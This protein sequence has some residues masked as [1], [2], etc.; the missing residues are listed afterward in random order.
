[1]TETPQPSIAEDDFDLDDW[2]STGTLARRA[3][4]IYNDPALAAEYDILAEQV[5]AAERAAVAGL[6]A[7]GAAAEAAMGDDTDLPELYEEMA[8][9][10]ER[11]E[12]SKAVWIVR[13]LVEDEVDAI[14]KLHPDPEIPELIRVEKKP[15]EVWSEEQLAAGRQYRE[16][17][18]AALTARNLAMIAKAVVEVRTPRGV[19]RT[20]DTRPAVTVEQMRALRGRP[21]GEAQ[22]ARLLQAVESA[23]TGEV[24]VP[25]PTSP[26][27]SGSDRG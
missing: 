22:T 20:T 10:H 8:R 26:G 23:T 18:A 7:G 14:T 3:V 21:H 2:L 13:A 17:R 1:V 9:L 25:R 12:A 11:W 6:S 15:G 16:Q 27:R 4:A 5:E 19:R 24:E